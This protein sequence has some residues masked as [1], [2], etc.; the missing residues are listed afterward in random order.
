MGLWGNDLLSG[1]I[2]MA[3]WKIFM[4]IINQHMANLRYPAK[5]KNILAGK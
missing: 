5:Q 1:V 4:K 2:K 3:C